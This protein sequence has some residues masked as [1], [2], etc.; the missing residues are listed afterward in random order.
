M[1]A[2]LQHLCWKFLLFFIWVLIIPNS[3]Q[4]QFKDQHSV[5]AIVATLKSPTPHEAVKA[6][7]DFD[8][9]LMADGQ[10]E[11]GKVYLVTDERSDRANEL[12]RKLLEA[13]GEDSQNWVVR[14]LD[15]DPPIINAF[16]TGGKYIYV[17]TGLMKEAA[18]DDELAFV[19]SHELGHSLLKH[20][21][22][23]K[24]DI[25][26][27]IAGI[28]ELIALFSKNAEDYTGF[29]KFIKSSYNRVDEEE[30][31]AIAVAIVRRVGLNPLRG[32][33][34]FSR[35]KRRDEKTW[36]ET[37]QR[38]EQMQ[39]EVQQAQ[40]N[41]QHWHKWYNSSWLNQ[42]KE[43]ANKVNAICSDAE[44]KRIEY[45]QF[46]QQYNSTL[47][48]QQV[49]SFFSTH[50]Q[51]Q[52]RIAAITVLTDYVFGRRE[53][54]SLSR[55]QQSYRVMLALKQIDSVLLKPPAKPVIS[56]NAVST[57]P[58]KPTTS[59]ELSEQLMQLKRAY[60]D[61]LITDAE[62]EQKRQQILNRY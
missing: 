50:P 31:D 13:M 45:N 49:D 39:Q 35:G 3:T 33:D 21:L 7:R 19:L 28:A 43:N 24:E 23:A 15:T 46:V 62:Y 47:K 52:N 51:D 58:S 1:R 8:D 30:A 9:K 4:A 56:P 40:A 20:G 26:S 61:G 6:A 59:K 34:F 17:F 37:Q 48:Q 53:L 32:A 57:S 11:G 14:V 22:R 29:S 42:T 16:V 25:T 18:S 36:Q 12:V 10:L 44:S 2:A 5:E 38:L 55:F 54:Q 27:T 60:E 41:C